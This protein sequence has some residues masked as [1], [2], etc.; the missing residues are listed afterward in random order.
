MIVKKFLQCLLILLLNFC[1]LHAQILPN[2]SLGSGIIAGTNGSW[3]S[4]SGEFVFGF[5][6]LENNLYLMGIW[7]DKIPEKTL[8]W[9]ANRNSPAETGSIIRLTF[10]GQLFLTFSNGSVQTVYNDAAASL[11]FMQ[12]D[13][14]FVLRDGSSRVLWQSFDSPTETLLPGQVLT[15]GKKLFSDAK[16][17]INYSTGNFM[18]EMQ[19]DGNL[20]LFAYHFS[21]P[22]YWYTGTLAIHEPCLVNAVCGVNGMCTSPDNKTVACNCIP[23]YIPFDPND[24]SKGCHP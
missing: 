17:I 24:V 3:Q 22:G 16:G 21:D 18:L 12:N 15:T 5:Y 14:N 11:G 10:A 7:L 2:I 1:S 4:L 9:S 23:G 20:V 13:G 8:V 19:H 6:P